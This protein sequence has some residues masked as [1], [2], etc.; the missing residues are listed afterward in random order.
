[1]PCYFLFSL[2]VDSVISIIMNDLIG[3]NTGGEIDLKRT[4]AEAGV[5]IGTLADAVCAC[6][7]YPLCVC[8]MFVVYQMAYP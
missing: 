6:A 4:T 5:S 3:I 7:G 2:I 8:K 1:M